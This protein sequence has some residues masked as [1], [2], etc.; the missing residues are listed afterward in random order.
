MNSSEQLSPLLRKHGLEILGEKIQSAV[1][2]AILFRKQM[3][4]ETVTGKS[5]F[6]GL[7]PGKPKSVNRPQPL[8]P[9]CSHLG[10]LPELPSG[11]EWP[12]WKGRPLTLMAQINCAETARIET[13]GLWPKSGTL[14]FFYDLKEQPWGGTV[15]DIGSWVVKFVEEPNLQPTP[16]PS[17]IREFVLPGYAVKPERFSTL[18][19]QSTRAFESLGL[20]E[21]Q[22][23]GFIELSW[24]LKHNIC[25]NE[26]MHQSLGYADNIQGDVRDEW[27]E[28]SGK[29][30]MDG[31]GDWKLLLQFDTDNELNVMW[32]DAGMLYFGIRESDFRARKFEN[33]MMT[34]QCS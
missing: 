22:S 1:H 18:P 20:D 33:V 12:R 16:A 29:A 19:G 11:F 8:T 10:G 30:R 5:S 14:Y 23:E 7:I 27:E 32:G 13:E 4:S 25:G 24:E 9:G 26:S 2:P 3:R 28:L 31:E 21:V 17:E 34:M 6:F 15:G